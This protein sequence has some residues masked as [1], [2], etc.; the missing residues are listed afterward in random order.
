[1]K[2]ICCCLALALLSLSCQAQAPLQ[3]SLQ[4][5]LPSNDTLLIYESITEKVMASIPLDDPFAEHRFLLDYPTTGLLKV[6]KGEKTYLSLLTPG[7]KM[8]VHI[9]ADG[10]LSTDSQADSLLNYLWKSNNN[11][12]AEKG[13]FIFNTNDT[14]S[15]LHLFD[16]FRLE[17]K[18]YINAQA[19]QLDTVELGILHHQNEARIYSFLF[20]F[21]RLAMQ[22]PPEHPFFGFI[23][24]IDPELIWAKTLPQNILYKYE[25]EYLMTHDTLDNLNAFTHFIAAQTKDPDLSAFY[26]AIYLKEL[27][28]NPSY[29]TKHE[30]LFNAAVLQEALE[31]EKHNPYYD[32]IE[33]ASNAFFSAQQGEIAYDFT[34]ERVDGT[35]LSLSDLKGKLVFI[36][37]WATWCGPCLSQRPKVLQMAE[38]YKDHPDIVFLMISVDASKPRWLN[39]LKDKTKG[40]QAG[41]DLLI[42]SGMDTEYGEQFN[43]RFIPKYMLIDEKGIIINADL[44]E[45]G[46]GMERI[47]EVALGKMKQKE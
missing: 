43:I 32:L 39:F 20:Y 13:V 1:M 4:V 3:L 38:K 16:A 41:L 25:L 17:R 9:A 42:V 8:L 14:D 35:T 12:I 36:D 45:P 30:Q 27:M 29:W 33:T 11:F 18:D 40:E 6:K 34:A 21:G 37:T 2:N 7:K 15:I 10:A 28:E 44:P 22:F 46:L 31:K 19:S 24:A 23:K 26:T 5:D 47:I